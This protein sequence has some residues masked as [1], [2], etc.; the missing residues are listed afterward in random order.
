MSDTELDQLAIGVQTLPGR[1]VGS[2]IDAPFRVSQILST[3]GL[4]SNPPVVW[5]GDPANPVEV[6][7]IGKAWD[8]HPGDT[9]IYQYRDGMSCIVGKVSN[10][11]TET[12]P[13]EDDYPPWIEAGS[14]HPDQP[15][16]MNSWVWWGSPH[17]VPG[18]YQQSDGWV[19]LKGL[20]KS[21][22]TAV[23]TI[24]MRD[25]PPPAHSLYF[26]VR[27]GST[28]AVLELDNAGQLKVE[29]APNNSYLSFGGITYPGPNNFA[30]SWDSDWTFFR[31]YWEVPL[32]QT[33]WNKAAVGESEIEIYL[34]SDGWCW[35]K[36]VLESATVPGKAF[37]FPD[38]TAPGWRC[39]MLT[40]FGFGVSRLDCGGGDP[41][42]NRGPTTMRVES[43]GGSG[44]D[45]YLGGINWW[46][47]GSQSNTHESMGA[48]G[49]AYANGW[50]AFG[51]DFLGGRYKKDSHGI[52]H[53]AGLVDGTGSTSD[54]IA[55][56]PEGYRPLETHV[57]LSIFGSPSN[58]VGRIDVDASG[59]II[60]VT[61]PNTSWATLNGCT[62]RAE[63]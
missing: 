29:V 50:S 46:G 54:A 6:R 32:F 23:N 43:G 34:R 38:R 40:G 33:G 39:Q 12:D 31:G 48:T 10:V 49:I 24:I 21:G 55:A 53:L 13:T 35:M 3:D 36:G 51:T 61:H 2:A 52:V 56:L 19:R 30:Y 57:F 14:G 15:V 28:G 27:D 63:Q 7:I 17:A 18:Y 44:Q 22:T 5:I 20:V 58:S 25:L 42:S 60:A 45:H 8:Y 26:P 62:F 37:D 41:S 11:G 4:R 47:R 1:P 16:L 59:T 9:V